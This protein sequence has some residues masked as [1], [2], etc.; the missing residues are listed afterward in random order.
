MGVIAVPAIQA[1]L[2]SQSLVAIGLGTANRS[3][4][5]PDVPTIAEQGLRNY[6]VDG[7]FGVIGPAKLPAADVQRIH[8]AF[9]M[10]MATPDVKDAMQKQG[11]VISPTTPDAAAL[12]F[13][14]EKEKY[15]RIVKAADV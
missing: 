15:A 13:R 6:V 5:L 14:E 3:P 8:D 1:H 11:N 7:W 9:V 10:A 2:K 4:I 12:F